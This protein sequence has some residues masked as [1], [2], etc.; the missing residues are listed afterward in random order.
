MEQRTKEGE[1]ANEGAAIVETEAASRLDL[2]ALSLGMLDL[3]HINETPAPP[4]PH[5]K[6]RGGGG[7]R[8][9]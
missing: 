2:I 3:A 7:E 8:E 6:R 4:L 1:E 9:S 5:W